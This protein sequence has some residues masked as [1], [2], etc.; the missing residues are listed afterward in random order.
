MPNKTVDD[1]NTRIAQLLKQASEQELTE[2]LKSEESLVRA[3]HNQNNQNRLA[4]K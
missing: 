1:M 2:I 4:E 3:A